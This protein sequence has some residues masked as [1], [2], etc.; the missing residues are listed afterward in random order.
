MSKFP[1]SPIYTQFFK[2]PYDIFFSLLLLII[3]SP[4]FLLI[5]VC[6]KIVSPKGPVFYG[7]MRVGRNH[8]I[9][10]CWKFRTMVPD[11]DEKLAHYLQK[12]PS[13]QAEYARDFKIKKD[14][15]IIPVIGQILRFS[16]LDEVPQFF[17][18]LLGQMSMI[19]PRPVT[20]EEL[21]RYKDQ[22]EKLLSVRPGITGWWQVSGRNDISY[23]QRVQLDMYYIDHAN[24]LF[25]TKITLKTMLVIL[26]HKGY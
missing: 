18:V 24:I 22:V 2:R 12:N 9:F 5:S 8:E 20:K 19:G 1:H 6:I 3:L 25:D 4:L 14:P 7:H 11:A 17:N 15:R 10:K 26:L 13:L 23:E 16:S 21:F